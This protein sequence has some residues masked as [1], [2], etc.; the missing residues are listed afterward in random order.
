MNNTENKKQ[1]RVLF[2]SDVH[3]GYTK[4][5]YG[6][7]SEERAQ[8]WVDSIKE[9]HRRNPIDL[10]IFV[11]DASLDHYI[12]KGSY[13]TD[14]ISTTDEF[15]K[16]YMSQ[17]PR[18]IPVFMCPG[19]HELYSNEQ[20]QSLTGNGRSGTVTLGEDLFIMLDSFAEQLE[21]NFDKQLAKYTPANVAY[22]REQMEKYPDKRV[23]LVSHWFEKGAESEEFKKLLCEEDR[24]K[25]LFAGHIH[26][27]DYLSL[28]KEY[29]YKCLAYTG[30]F[31]Y[32][33]YTA[34]P[35]G[36][37]N[38][39]YDSFWGFREL[40]IYPSSA[41]SNYIRVKTQIP[42]Y[43]DIPYDLERKLTFGI[44]YLY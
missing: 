41:Q 10:I 16:K 14:G 33:Y 8:H 40:L 32:S 29:G 34:Y 37:V 7:P 24:I 11:G 31:S 2:T 4:T 35:S 6:Y 15:I 20:W 19:N 9:E 38:D 17:L 21:P 5:W 43:R 18:E 25:G 23:W 44:E 12:D 28:G 42:T 39:L 30:E 26:R 27:G 36:D 22:I 13:T 3:Y 1:M